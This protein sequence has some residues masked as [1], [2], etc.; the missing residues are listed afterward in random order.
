M[1]GV[2][3]GRELVNGNMTIHDIDYIINQDTT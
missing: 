1:T 3:D 2:T